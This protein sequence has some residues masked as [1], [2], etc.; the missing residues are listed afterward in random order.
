[1]AKA[2]RNWLAYHKAVWLRRG[3]IILTIAGKKVSDMRPCPDCGTKSLVLVSKKQA[4]LLCNKCKKQHVR[5]R[6]K[7]APAPAKAHEQK[8]LPMDETPS[9]EGLPECACCDRPVETKRHKYCVVHKGWSYARK[10]EAAAIKAN[11]DCK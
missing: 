3:F 10:A 4:V 6:K 8:P 1:M 9:S 5:G 2:I 11:P 7:K